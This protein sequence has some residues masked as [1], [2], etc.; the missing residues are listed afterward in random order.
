M[1]EITGQINASLVRI[2]KIMH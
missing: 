2:R 1:P